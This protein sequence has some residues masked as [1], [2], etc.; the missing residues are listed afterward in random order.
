MGQRLEYQGGTSSKFWEITTR[1]RHVAVR[2]GRIGT[3]G[4]QHDSTYASPTEAR[5]AAATLMRNKLAKGY[6]RARV[7][8]TSKAS[9]QASPSRIARGDRSRGGESRKV[10]ALVDEIVD[11]S[12]QLDGDDVQ[13]GDPVPSKALAKAV[14]RGGHVFP[15]SY[16]AFLERHNG[17]LNLSTGQSLVGVSGPITKEI[18]DDIRHS[19]IVARKAV[20]HDAET[21]GDTVDGALAKLEDRERRS[22]SVI[23]PLRHPVF[24]TDFNGGV[25]LFDQAHQNRGEPEV[26]AVRNGELLERWKSFT[27]WLEAAVRDLKRQRREAGS[28]TKARSTQTT[29]SAKRTTGRP[30]GVVDTAAL[31]ALFGEKTRR[32]L[33]GL[34]SGSDDATLVVWDVEHGK[35]AATLS[36]HKRTRDGG[37]FGVRGAPRAPVAAS[38]AGDLTLQL[39]N[40]KTGTSLGTL[41]TATDMVRD[42]AFH[43]REALL[44]AIVDYEVRIWNLADGDLVLTIPERR[45]AA[46]AIL[47]NTLGFDPDGRHVVVV[48]G[49]GEAEVYDLRNG[50]RVDSWRAVPASADAYDVNRL[51]WSPNGKRLSVSYLEFVWFRA[52]PGPDRGRRI[53]SDR[54]LNDYVWADDSEGFVLAVSDG[55][56]AWTVDDKQTWWSPVKRGEGTPTVLASRPDGGLVAEGTSKGTI[57]LR[58]VTDGDVVA[59]LKGHAKSVSALTFVVR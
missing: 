9:D 17:A 6:R 59:T 30:G 57:R 13:V 44:G 54:G 38:W 58:S 15:P 10:A 22:R 40:T 18:K 19:L 56:G 8:A 35:R 28:R 1:G 49:A 51:R 24:G 47:R 3:T 20:A 7:R 41:A 39:W 21:A 27:H 50:A 33:R 36:G 4:Q 31:A 2:F 37:L 14:G 55:V 34:V 16:R 11:L 46:G 32:D 29:A 52:W 23:Q 26:V 42:A 5:R 53:S 43:P 48:S 45:T 12:R 25:L